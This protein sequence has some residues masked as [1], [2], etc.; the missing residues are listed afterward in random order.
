L[1]TTAANAL[2]GIPQE[3]SGGVQ[4]ICRSA[5]AYRATETQ[6]IV[7]PVRRHRTTTPAAPRRRVFIQ[8]ILPPARTQRSSSVGVWQGW[9]WP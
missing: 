3:R 6:A 5:S 2:G 1:F 8:T 4:R 9:I 7:L